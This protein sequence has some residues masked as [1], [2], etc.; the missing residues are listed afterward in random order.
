MRVLYYINLL[1][2]NYEDKEKNINIG[3]IFRWYQRKLRI[4]PIRPGQQSDRCYWGELL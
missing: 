1:N 2:C 4:Y 3:V